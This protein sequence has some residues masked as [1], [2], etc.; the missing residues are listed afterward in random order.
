MLGKAV[1]G[2]RETQTVIDMIHKN[3][4][5]KIRDFFKI[6]FMDRNIMRWRKVNADGKSCGEVFFSYWW[7]WEDG[8]HCE[9]AEKVAK[10]H[11]LR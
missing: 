11:E 3:E 10:C 8:R 2:G 5:H 1:A 7:E 6:E 9:R 4:R